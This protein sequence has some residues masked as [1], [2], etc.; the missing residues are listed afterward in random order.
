LKISEGEMGPLAT[1]R[2]PL[3]NTK[4]TE[5]MVNLDVDGHTKNPTSLKIL[6]KT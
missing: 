5:I 1:V 2:G 3:A 6:Q 4:K